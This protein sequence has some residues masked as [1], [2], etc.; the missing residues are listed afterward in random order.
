MRAATGLPN[1]EYQVRERDALTL[2]AFVASYVGCL[3]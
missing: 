3:C 2:P 1:G